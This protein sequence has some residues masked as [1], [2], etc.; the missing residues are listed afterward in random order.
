MDKGLIKFVM[1][2]AL[3]IWVLSIVPMNYDPDTT[4]ALMRKIVLALCVVGAFIAHR[5]RE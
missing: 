4:N 1:Y 2:T 3:A 5:D